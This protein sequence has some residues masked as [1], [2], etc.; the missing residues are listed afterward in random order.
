MQSVLF[1][2]FALAVNPRNLML[3]TMHAANVVLQSKLLWRRIK[4]ER[5]PGMFETVVPA[6]KMEEKPVVSK[7]LEA[8]P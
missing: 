3:F 6:I 4:F 1:M 8:K 7:E 5:N 2:K